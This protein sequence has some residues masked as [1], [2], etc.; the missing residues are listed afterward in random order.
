MIDD[1]HCLVQAST[2]SYALAAKR[3]QWAAFVV[4]HATYLA[5]PSLSEVAVW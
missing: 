2:V 4:T 3:I 1:L 5:M